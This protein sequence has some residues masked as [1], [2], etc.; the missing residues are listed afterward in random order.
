[1]DANAAFVAR[2]RLKTLGFVFTAL[3]F[4]E[5]AWVAFC[6]FGGFVLGLVGL[7]EE[8]LLMAAGLGGVYLALALFNGIVAALHLWTGRSLRKGR[9]MMLLLASIAACCANFVL[10]LYCLPFTMGAL[11]FAFVTLLDADV[12]EVLDQG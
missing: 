9:G 4:I 3:G 8:D 11:I 6:I 12:R 1:M 7:V 10:A 5:L 2:G